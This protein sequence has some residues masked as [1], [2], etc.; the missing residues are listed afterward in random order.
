MILAK[1]AEI[2]LS[3][4]ASGKVSTIFQKNIFQTVAFI[5]H[6]FLFFFK[7]Y[8]FMGLLGSDWPAS[9]ALTTLEVKGL[10]VQF[11][12]QTNRLHFIDLKKKLKN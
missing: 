12:F 3:L 2:F 11:F 5:S 10:E 9:I 7:Y 1:I 6:I 8:C 4:F